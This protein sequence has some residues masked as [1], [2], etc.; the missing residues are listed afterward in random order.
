MIDSTRPE[1][2][3]SP[4][5]RRTLLKAAGVAAAGTT[6]AG[7]GGFTAAA[8]PGSSDRRV[9]VLGGGVAGLTA[10]HELA[11][12]GFA[13]TVYER[14]AFGGK[15]KSMYRP[16]TGTGGRRDLPG[17]HGHRGYFGFYRHL[18]D[19]LG[20]IPFPGNANGVLGNLV[21]LADVSLARTDLPD[22]V[23]TD[24]VHTPDQINLESIGQ[25]LLG[26]LA[27]GVAIPPW[28]AAYVVD[29]I[30]IY[31]SSCHERRY[32]QWE[33][34]SWWDY[35]G[36]PARSVDYQRVF[37]GSA[38]IIQALK[39]QVASARTAGQ[40]IESILYS[41]YLQ[42]PG[43]SG[44]LNRVMGAPTN[45]AWIDPWVRHLESLGVEFR[46][47]AEVVGL[48][49]DGDRIGGARVRGP[50]GTESVTADWF[51]LAVPL[52]R[53]VPLL[54]VPRI[55]ERDPQFEKLKQLQTSWSNG[56]QFYLNTQ[57]QML[58]GHVAHIDSP[59]KLVSLPQGQIWREN[60]SRTWGSG[61]EQECLSVVVSDWV[62]EPG[63]LYGKPASR[64]TPQEVANEVWEQMKR[65]T[66]KWGAQVL[67]DN[68][69]E[70]YF[71]DPAAQNL[72]SDQPYNDE[73]YFLNT[74]GSWE[75][76][77]TAH[78]AIPNLFL[79]ADYVQTPKNIDF[80]SMEAANEAGRHAVNAL[81]DT[82]GSRESHAALFDGYN[83]PELASLKAV[84]R[85]RYLAGQP[86]IMDVG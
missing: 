70:S 20:R 77:P 78:T 2:V 41:G 26:T 62:Q 55:A 27:H 31:L 75:L 51:V 67:T 7:A 36:A 19:T 65:H 35:I 23:L 39:A 18:P 3:S 79:A 58:R 74:V 49:L 32:G 63:V 71:I 5:S 13:V 17:E 66:N 15:A 69:I 14:K 53:A 83:P 29:R 61:R 48:D 37:G 43:S 8:A 10:A 56:I 28:E 57:P 86:H 24:P 12:R 72:G 21:T 85:G 60:F 34:V 30:L 44:P 40:G 16:G 45:E 33:H 80:T 81:L 6:L 22:W 82:A 68:M 73:R 42:L 76:R 59:W 46:L 11:E 47:P 64:C 4:F 25:M 50:Q 38:Q 84:D 9:A 54:T 52:E 1:T